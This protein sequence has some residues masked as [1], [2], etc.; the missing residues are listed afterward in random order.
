MSQLSE[1]K[2]WLGSLL[3]NNC[4]H[5]GKLLVDHLTR[6]TDFLQCLSEKHRIPVDSNALMAMGLTHDIGKV[7]PAFQ[8]Y[9]NGKGVGVNHSETSSWFTLSL[10]NTIGPSWSQDRSGFWAAE[11][12]RRHHTRMRDTIDL[13]SNWMGEGFK[14]AV[15][16]VNKALSLVPEWE[17]NMSEQDLLSLDDMFL[18]LGNLLNINDWYQAKIF[19]SLLVSADRMEALGVEEIS[20]KSLPMPLKPV[21]PSREE[22]IDRWREEL[23]R[24]CLDLAHQV[25]GPGVYSL[26]LPTGAGKTWIGLSAAYDWYVRF[27]CQSIIYCLPFISIVEQT[28]DAAEKMFGSEYVQEDHSLAYG[29]QVNRSDSEDQSAWEKMSALFRF[30]REPLVVTTL[31]GLWEALFNPKANSTMNFSRLGNSVVIIDEPQSIPPRKWNSFGKVLNLIS[32]KT[33]AIFLLMT[34]TQPLIPCTSGVGPKEVSFPKNRHL[35]LIW[36]NKVSVSEIV[37]LVSQKLPVFKESG[38]MVVNRKREALTVYQQFRGIDNKTPTLFLSGWMTPYMRRVVL[39]YLKFLEK[40]EL[41]RHLVSTQVVEAGVDLDFDWVVRDMGPLDSIIQVAGRCNR[42]GG[43]EEPG[44]VLVVELVNDKGP[45]WKNVYDPVSVER[46]KEAISEFEQFTETEVPLII[47]KYYY[48]IQDGLQ[49]ERIYEALK[50]GKWTGIKG[51]YEDDE[52]YQN[53][54]VFVEERTEVLEMIRRVEEIKNEK[55]SFALMDE[56]KLLVKKLRRYAID[57]PFSLIKQ[58]LE[59]NASIETEEDEPPFREVFD[60]KAYLISK[61]ALKK[62][63]DDGKAL[64]YKR[65]GLYPPDSSDSGHIL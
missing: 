25:E 26:T 13:Y 1:M 40:K 51:L 32:Q 18:D 27:S 39:R 50:E 8:K 36:Q 41:H 29:D 30:W 44:K 54:T 6:T 49:E 3:G 12:V 22:K 63:I 45:L 38:L 48:A 24:T 7:H 47:N 60:G 34:A 20:F 57:I 11:A 43:K 23:S 19:Y 65:C 35:Y 64:Y 42:H 16:K 9:L 31:V 4:S 33:G 5:P 62:R 55:M 10:I 14:D 53:V 56:Q 21:F 52:G 15:D 58:C 46:T 28:S 59:F 61:N 2:T 37:K 17:R